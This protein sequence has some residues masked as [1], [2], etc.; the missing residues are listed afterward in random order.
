[1]SVHSTGQYRPRRPVLR[2]ERDRE[3]GAWDGACP[4]MVDLH[5]DI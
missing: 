2:E 1:M 3:A 4:H 5:A